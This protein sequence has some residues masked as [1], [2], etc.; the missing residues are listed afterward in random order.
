MSRP[1]GSVARPALVDMTNHTRKRVFEVCG[2]KS[3]DG[4][5]EP[6]VSKQVC[7]GLE[8]KCEGNLSENGLSD[9]ET[10]R[11]GKDPV[12]NLNVVSEVRG[13]VEGVNVGACVVEG[14]ESGH[15]VVDLDDV[16]RDSYCSMPLVPIGSE[17]CNR[18]SSSEEILQEN[19]VRAALSGSPHETSLP[20]YCVGG[21]KDVTV[22]FSNLDQSESSES[23]KLV[24]PS[25]VQSFELERCTTFKGDIN[26]NISFAADMLKTCSCSFCLKVCCIFI[27]SCLYMV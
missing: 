24:K 16:S 21:D 6:P 18:D 7:I 26:S 4:R 19:V 2:G 17:S 20:G 10:D 1:T 13:A 25:G 3:N 14:M 27:F 12:V 9:C 11:V 8:K 22:A 23:A 5:G 15:N